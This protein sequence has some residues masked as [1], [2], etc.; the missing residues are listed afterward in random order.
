MRK[1][2]ARTRRIVLAGLALFVIAPALL[3]AGSIQAEAA[4]PRGVPSVAPLNPCSDCSKV[5]NFSVSYNKTWKFVSK[6]LKLCVVFDAKGSISYTLWY[7]IAYH[8]YYYLWT[9]Q[10]LKSPELTL[11]VERSSCS[12]SKTTTKVDIGQHWT[13]YS[14]S[15]N[16]SISVAYPWAVSISGWPS[17][18]NRNQAEYSTGYGKGSVY[19]QYNTGS[20]S[21]FGNYDSR[22]ATF[23]Y[24]CYGVFASGIMWEGNTSDSYSAGNSSGAKSVC[25][26]KR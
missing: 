16:P 7:V 4:V 1:M 5:G 9:N 23:N 26:S 3:F 6:P 21:S 22:V 15:F 14:C 8:V 24:P 25:L 12:G 13:G 20:P 11:T 10:T 18:G 19:H 2:Q 17:C